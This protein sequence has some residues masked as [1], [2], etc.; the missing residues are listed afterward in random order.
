[1]FHLE[2]HAWVDA[3][4]TAHGV[5]HDD[6]AQYHAYCTRRLARL[7][8][9]AKSDLVHSSKY[10]S[11]LPLPSPS[12]STCT[13]IIDQPSTTTKI[14]K[15][16]SKSR[17]AFCSR[18]H[19]TF[20]LT[21]EVTVEAEDATTSSTTT[22]AIV[23][24]PVPHPNILW[25]LLVNAERSWAHAN[26]LQKLKTSNNNNTNNSNSNTT[27]K[28]RIGR[29]PLLKKLKRAVKW[30]NLL[31]EKA[32][33]SADMETQTECAAY[34]AWMA[35]NLALEK[36][37]Y[38]TATNDYARAMALCYELSEGNV[39]DGT[40]VDNKD[41]KNL[42]RH[43]LFVTRAELVIRPL[44]RYCQY[45]L[46][47]AGKPTMEEPRLLSADTQNARDNKEDDSI[48]FRDQELVLDNKELRVLLIK[49]QSL[50]QEH[51]DGAEKKEEKP[52][53]KETLYITSLSILDDAIE[54][55]QSLQQRL[56][57][58]T[59]SGGP[60]IQAKLRQ[61]SLWVGYLQYTKTTKVMEHTEHLLAI[62]MSP[63]EK[64]HVYE[65]V[66]QH[67]KGLLSLPGS[68]GGAGGTDHEDDEFILQVQAN[69]LRLRAL[70]TYQ[71]GLC[72]YTQLYKYGPALALFDHS[73]ALCK[74]AQEEIAACD[75]DMPHANAYLQQLEE[76]P[77]SSG[78]AAVR[79]A[80]VLQQRQ[81]TRKLQKAGAMTTAGDGT[82]SSW[83]EPITTDRPLLLRLYEY[84][85]GSL[86]API[87][88][89]RPIPLPCKPAFYDLAYGY[90]LDQS[91]SADAIKEFIY[92]HTVAPISDYEEETDDN[93]TG[94]GIFGW[95]TGRG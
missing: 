28:N 41:V 85:G 95:L 70:K 29:Q 16:K 90:A 94:G 47:Q 35:A 80:M 56:S 20:A 72:Y 33:T 46:K 71:M 50:D 23:P 65:A 19:D 88:D 11:P 42:E 15:S 44:F 39:S 21:Q 69:I 2:I 91:N 10:A 1:M 53:T 84:D 36:M 13:A 40:A 60:A 7:A 92:E 6:Y 32:K 73:S 30:S 89:L 83:Q 4:Q 24:V 68:D 86:E 93:G 75:E 26:E 63:A 74:S 77:V 58:A 78:I 22:T 12:P 54:V 45:E 82:A 55:V 3:Q 8:H 87:A 67:A 14:A 57:T 52:E 17:H 34:A 27:N 81:H 59:S 48:I 43:D 9:G 25:N 76:L 79:A 31:V 37:D 51:K 66:L 38:E 61:Y 5:R 62:E 64:V 18:S 49:L